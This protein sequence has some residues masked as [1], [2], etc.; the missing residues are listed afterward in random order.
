MLPVRSTGHRSTFRVAAA[1]RLAAVKVQSGLRVL[2]A[3]QKSSSGHALRVF[4]SK[5][6]DS[7][8]R[9]KKTERLYSVGQLFGVTRLH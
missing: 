9:N 8:H 5:L 7:P 3:D 1:I 6:P 2:S 4:W